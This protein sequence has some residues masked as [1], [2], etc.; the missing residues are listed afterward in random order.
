MPTLNRQT[1]EDMILPRRTVPLPFTVKEIQWTSLPPGQMV[2]ATG[3]QGLPGDRSQR[4]PPFPPPCPLLPHPP[5]ALSYLINRTQVSMGWKWSRDCF[6]M[7][8]KQPLFDCSRQ[9]LR[10]FQGSVS[11]ENKEDSI[12]SPLNCPAGSPR[13]SAFEKTDEEQSLVWKGQCVLNPH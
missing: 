9:C 7:L 5:Q 1:R 3:E 4:H 8:Y 13:A 10:L 11:G 12:A 2:P 6:S